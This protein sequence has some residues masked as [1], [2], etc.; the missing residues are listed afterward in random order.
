MRCVAAL[1]LLVLAGLVAGC[2]NE[3]LSGSSSGVATDMA[4]AENAPEQKGAE[5]GADGSCEA[6][7][8][9]VGEMVAV[10]NELTATRHIRTTPRTMA[11]LG[12]RAIDVHDA[13]GDDSALAPTRTELADLVRTIDGLL[14]G[15]PETVE[16]PYDAPHY[17]RLREVT[18]KNLDVA[19]S[20]LAALRG[21]MESCD[22]RGADQQ[23]RRRDFLGDD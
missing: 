18:N 6:F 2:G 14:E 1:S 8:A 12:D 15:L 21:G 9:A 22:T 17:D 16:P 3:P 11:T 5:S 20:A 13:I 10:I 7:A 19:G 4:E 23:Q